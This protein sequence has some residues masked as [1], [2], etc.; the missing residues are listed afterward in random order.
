MKKET[1]VRLLLSAAKELKAV[2]H[3][4]GAG[5]TFLLG[6]EVLKT[7]TS[8]AFVVVVGFWVVMQVIAHAVEA[9]A[10]ELKGK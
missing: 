1:K 4:G 8:W 7:E 6:P 10:E 2:A 5:L 3:L 9:I